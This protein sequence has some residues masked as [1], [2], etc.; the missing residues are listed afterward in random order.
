[1]AGDR[2]HLAALCPHMLGQL[3][4][5]RLQAV[6]GEHQQHIIGARCRQAGGHVRGIKIVH[7]EDAQ[8]RQPQRQRARVQ[9]VLAHAD[10]EHRPRAAQCVRDG[11]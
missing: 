7:G 10:D 5:R 2:D 8:L 11:G 1:M 9:V 3:A 4:E 6:L